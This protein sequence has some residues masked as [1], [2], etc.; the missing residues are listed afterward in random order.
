MILINQWSSTDQPNIFDQIKL[1]KTLI[2]Y[3]SIWL[4][5]NISVLVTVVIII[6]KSLRCDNIKM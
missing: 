2:S 4:S 5:N 6:L 3:Q 1:F